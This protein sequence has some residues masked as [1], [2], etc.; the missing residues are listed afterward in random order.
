M[1]TDEHKSPVGNDFPYELFIHAWISNRVVVINAEPAPLVVF[2]IHILTRDVNVVLSQ[3]K[4][5]IRPLSIS[6]PGT[7]PEER[8]RDCSPVKLC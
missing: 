3:S 5:S 1:C 7:A 6:V 8:R 2:R 4:I